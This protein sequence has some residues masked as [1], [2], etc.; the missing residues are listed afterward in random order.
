M[1]CNLYRNPQQ[2]SAVYIV[3]DSNAMQCSSYS[4][5]SQSVLTKAIVSYR[6]LYSYHK[7]LLAIVSSN[8]S[9]HYL[10]SALTICS[11]DSDRKLPIAVD[12]SS[13]C[14]TEKMQNH[15]GFICLATLV[16]LLY[17][18]SSNVFSNCLLEKRHSHTGCMCSTFLHCAFSNVSS[19]G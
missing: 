12:V 10:S 1:Q 9:Y 8:D 3:I 7:L 11:N 2:C 5:D 15:I 18:V 16:V 14:L 4:N 17:C 19:N 6:K 13:N